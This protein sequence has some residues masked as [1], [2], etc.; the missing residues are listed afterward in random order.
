VQRHLVQRPAE[1]NRGEVDRQ[2]IV[3]A[4]RHRMGVPQDRRA[5]LEVGPRCQIE[6]EGVQRPRLGDRRA[7]GT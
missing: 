1:A 2:R 7:D 6:S 3:E 4:E 5:A